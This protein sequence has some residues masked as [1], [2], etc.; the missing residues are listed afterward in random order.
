MEPLLMGACVLDAGREK[1]GWS[2]I[3]VISRD[4]RSGLRRMEKIWARTTRTGVWR[5][6]GEM[7]TSPCSCANAATV[8]ST[9]NTLSVQL[10]RQ[11][12]FPP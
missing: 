1:V 2:L 6:K 10:S 11:P 5:V 12:T 8:S 9:A 7:R 3:I 4:R